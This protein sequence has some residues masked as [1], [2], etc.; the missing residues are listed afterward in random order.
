[1]IAR[2]TKAVPLIRRRGARRRPLREATARPGCH[3]IRDEL[4]SQGT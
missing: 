3:G 1:M 2:V 4:D